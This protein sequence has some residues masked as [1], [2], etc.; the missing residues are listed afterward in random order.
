[1]SLADSTLSGYAAAFDAFE[2]YCDDEGLSSLPAH[3]S[4]VIAY[5]GFLAKKGTLAAD[6]LQP[7]LSAIN[8]A[9]ADCGHPL[10]AS[11]RAISS[12]RCERG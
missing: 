5:V 3:W 12:A 4:T 11:E 7:T 9:H 1:M 8:R 10:P 6:S 2:A